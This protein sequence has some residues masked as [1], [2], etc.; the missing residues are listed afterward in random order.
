MHPIYEKLYLLLRCGS[1]KTVIPSRKQRR[2]DCNLEMIMGAVIV[3]WRGMLPA[4]PLW[5]DFIQPI[6]KDSI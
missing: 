5:R 3:G 2:K 1:T 4:F 6:Q